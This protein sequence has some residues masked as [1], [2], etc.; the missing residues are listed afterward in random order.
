MI[1]KFINVG[2][3]NF[4]YFGVVRIHRDID[5]FLRKDLMGCG[6]RLHLS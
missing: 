2:I 5:S 6:K 3:G 1:K 4:E